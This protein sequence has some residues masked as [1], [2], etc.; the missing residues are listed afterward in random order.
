MQIPE[1]G[2]IGPNRLVKPSRPS[3]ATKIFVLN[4]V[5]SSM[6]VDKRGKKIQRI[7]IFDNHPDSLRLVSQHYLN[8]NAERLR[9]RGSQWHVI[10]G[11]F[12]ILF[13][14]GAMFWPLLMPKLF[15]ANRDLNMYPGTATQ[16]AAAAS[17]A[18]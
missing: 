8:R 17:G 1:P 15:T 4:R 5:R 3:A 13:L 14:I 2:Q 16:V 11:L 7:L 18:R 9:P 6:V 10:L 12:L